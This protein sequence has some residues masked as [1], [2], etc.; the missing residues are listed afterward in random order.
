MACV[1]QDNGR[2]MSQI[3]TAADRIRSFVYAR[4]GHAKRVIAGLRRLLPDVL[5][6]RLMLLAER[7]AFHFSPAHQS[8]TLPPMFLHW[9]ATFV[10]PKFEAFGASSPEEL[11]FVEIMR[12]V[13]TRGRDAPLR[14]ISLGAGNC[15]MEVQLTV[16]LQAVGVDCRVVCVDINARNLETGRQ[17]ATD[18]GVATRM[19]FLCADCTDLRSDQRFDIAIVNQFFHHVEALETFCANLAGLLHDDGVL[20]SSDVVGRNGHLLWPDVAKE[21]DGLWQRLSDDQKRD[22]GDGRIK[23]T[24]Q[25]VDHAAYSNEGV[26]AQDVVACL[27]Q[28]FEFDVF[29]TFGAAIIPFVERRF[30]FNFSP[31]VPADVALIEEIARRDDALVCGGEVPAANMF[32]V[33]RKPGR[34]VRAM[35]VPIAP[36]VHVEL[37]RAQLALCQPR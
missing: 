16:R 19:E 20:L 32:A 17:A 30:G 5:E 2:D 8:D 37:T 1:V 11:Y 26:R 33:L 14:V 6:R 25:Q 28:R 10:R 34:A 15:A 18:A 29:L 35:H 21:V 7:L 13:E 22:R 12:H 27:L 23:Q 36:Q 3:V 4:R 24:Y 9:A 31:D